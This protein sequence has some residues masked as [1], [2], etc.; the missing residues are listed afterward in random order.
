MPH[1]NQKKLAVIHL[2]SL[3]VGSLLVLRRIRDGAVLKETNA[4][5]LLLE[6]DFS[7]S[8]DLML[9]ATLEFACASSEF[10]YAG[11]TI[12]STTL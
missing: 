1:Q 4:A 9:F 2:L 5:V 11:A 6:F 8:P 12:L 3:R 10:L 7:E